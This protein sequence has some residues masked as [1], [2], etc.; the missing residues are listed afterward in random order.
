[1]ARFSELLHDLAQYERRLAEGQARIA[2]Q[3]EFLRELDAEG[4]DTSFGAKRLLLMAANLSEME[5]HRQQI[6]RELS[7]AQKR[8]ATSLPH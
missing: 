3:A 7:A 4:H 1:M 2:R 8:A 6:L 5:R